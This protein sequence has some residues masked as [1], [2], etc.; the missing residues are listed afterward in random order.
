MPPRALVVSFDRLHIGYLGCYG[1]EWIETPNF[2]RLAAEGMTFDRH[3]SDSADA[4]SRDHAWWT[5]WPQAAIERAGCSPQPTCIEQLSQAGV[6]NWLLAETGGEL[7][8]VQIAPPFDQVITVRGA[9]GLDVTEGATPFARLVERASELLPEIETSVQP[10][11]LWLKSRGAPVP[12]L[13]PAEIADLYLDEFGLTN[14]TD[15]A[16]A[17]GEPEKTGRSRTGALDS[18]DDF[19][20]AWLAESGQSRD[21][22]FARCLYA[23]Y[24]THLDRWLGKLLDELERAGGRTR[25]LLIVTAAAGEPLG[26]H[27]ELAVRRDLLREEVMHTPMWVRAPDAGGAATRRPALVQP[28]DVAATLIDWFGSPTSSG[29]ERA[30]PLQGRS[31]LPLIRQESDRVR[32]G[33]LIA[34]SDEW[35]WR[36]DDYL[37]VFPRRTGGSDVESA[38]TRLFVKP[39]DRW[40]QA[41]VAAQFPDE[42]ERQRSAVTGQ[43]SELFAR[44]AAA[45]RSEIGD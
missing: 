40:D 11:L 35:G 10:A 9:D 24:V 31:L 42:V 28:A 26:E 30:G 7:D 22:K 6:R 1:N 21:L 15:D 33:I 25:W 41:D 45:S 43:L 14:E 27:G 23:A 5:G 8:R 38:E 3:Y 44:I 20:E 4:P 29:T 37:F 12:W 16:E 32:D 13:P 36:T 2:D 34:N 19:D 18:A 39:H 17:G